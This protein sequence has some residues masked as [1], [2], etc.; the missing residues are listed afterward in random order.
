M[1]AEI[2]MGGGADQPIERRIHLSYG[3]FTPNERRLADLVLEF[4]GD[5]AAYSATELAEL[6]GVSKATVSRFFRRLGFP[7]FEEARRVSRDAREAGSPV[8]LASSGADRSEGDENDIAL[9]LRDETD[10]IAR[11]LGRIDPES[12][13]RIARAIVDARNVVVLGYR[14]SHHLA[15]YMRG[16][17]AQMRRNV[18]LVP[19]G[20]D[21]PGDRLAGLNGDDLVIVV[22]MRRRVAPLEKAMTAL[23]GLGV[24]VV[25]I[26]DP[27]ARGLP[28]LARETVVCETE[29]RVLFDS[30]ASAMAV[31][32]LIAVSVVRLK[33]EV[34]RRHLESVEMLHEALGELES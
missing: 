11:T 29:T 14:N 9:F 10:A 26:T 13:G 2:I 16:L 3:R 6:A 25:L 21:T 12:I 5:L 30:Y 20:G 31:I 19:N 4:P 33:G 34:G 23:H 8:Y 27:T 17:L 7:T 22:G 1:G 32:R 24:P 18:E 28:A 15:A